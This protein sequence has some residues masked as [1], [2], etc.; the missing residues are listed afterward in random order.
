MR[1][2]L[3]LQTPMASALSAN[4]TNNSFLIFF[5]V[6]GYFDKRINY[7]HSPEVHKDTTGGVFRLGAHMDADAVSVGYIHDLREGFLE[8]G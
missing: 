4:D 7:L 2:A 5:E 6:L 3:Q 8:L 1:H